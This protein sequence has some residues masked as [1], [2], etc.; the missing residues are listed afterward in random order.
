M[1]A[2]WSDSVRSSVTPWEWSREQW[3][4][5]LEEVRETWG[6]A[7]YLDVV[8][9]LLREDPVQREWFLRY[10]RMSVAPGALI[11]E[12]WRYIDSDLRTA[13]PLIRVPTLVIGGDGPYEADGRSSRYVA[14]NVVGARLIELTEG[15]VWEWFDE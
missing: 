6:T 11:S 10:M 9:S 3:E 7:G 1:P 8:P 14:A 15:N 13:L 5:R 12:T 4:V 2:S